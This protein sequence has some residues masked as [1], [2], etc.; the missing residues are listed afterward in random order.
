MDLIEF[1]EALIGDV[2]N[3]AILVHREL[4]RVYWNRFTSGPC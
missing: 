2:L 3:A 4:G 1:D